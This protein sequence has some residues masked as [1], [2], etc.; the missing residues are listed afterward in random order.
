[1]RNADHPYGSTLRIPNSPLWIEAALEHTEALA[2]AVG[3]DAAESNKIRLATEEVL[4]FF[5]RAGNEGQDCPPVIL[6]LNPR[7]HEFFIRLTTKG[8][9]FDV[10]NLPAFDP[11]E[12]PAHPAL[13][14]LGL[15]LARWALN[16]ISFHNM[17]RE[18][19][20]A[21][22]IKNRPE[23]RVQDILGSSAMENARETGAQVP[24]KDFDIR[25][26][27]TG[28]ELEVS[29][30]AY[31]T[32]GHSYEGFIYYP[33]H[34]VEMNQDGRLRS[35]VAVTP[36]GDIMGHCGLK[37]SPEHKN[38]TELGV[39]FVRP[40]YRKNN[41]GGSLWKA[42]VDLARHE[43]FASVFARSVTGH[44]A[45]QR[46]AEENGFHDCCLFLNLCPP[47]VE[48]K[49]IGGTQ[50]GKMSLMLQWLGLHPPHARSIHPPERYAKITADLYR[51]AGIPLTEAE[52]APVPGGDPLLH[53]DR[54]PDLN[55]GILETEDIGS[56]PANVINWA[57]QCT[58]FLCREKLDTIY[59]FL[60]LEQPGAAEVA[61]AC[62]NGGF[63]FAGISP[64]HFPKADG[65]VMQYLNMQG[66]PFA[67][68]KTLSETA[69]MLRTF[70]RDEWTTREG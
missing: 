36:D 44:K 14:G 51:R 31:L 18:G 67:H 24:V 33:E 12:D 38:R 70:I 45:S 65:L 46:L 50:Q 68:L 53:F 49:S 62:A 9:P 4:E 32:Y 41:V 29:R 37:S 57:L 60:N 63:I 2:R 10:R 19:I 58:R 3:F 20:Q 40:K 6:H 42:A 22:L 56:A 15:H 1:M 21:E 28:E 17:G 5:L 34:I 16:R 25:P 13:D 54:I 66:D 48:L 35:L 47:N 27:R 64:N 8:M 69:R 7:A 23:A 11:Q 55:V 43:G 30:C 59:L 61:E 52:K 39:L 26:L